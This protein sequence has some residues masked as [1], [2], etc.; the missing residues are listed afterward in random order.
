MCAAH[1]CGC[2]QCI[3]ARACLRACMHMHLCVCV[4]VCVCTH[5]H[6]CTCVRVCVRA[7][8]CVCV[9]ARV[10]ACVCVCVCVHVRACACVCCV[11][12][13]V[14]LWLYLCEG[15]PSHTFHCIRT[16]PITSQDRSFT[17]ILKTPPASVMVKKAAGARGS[18]AVGICVGSV[19][20]FTTSA[21]RRGGGSHVT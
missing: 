15:I 7:C 12:V 9:R 20:G 8:V 10:R 1:A 4:C 5:A 6:V 14:C 2:F 17:F 18:V 16:S 21:Q 3:C 19:E 11:C 13:C